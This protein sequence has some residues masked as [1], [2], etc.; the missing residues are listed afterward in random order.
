MYTGDEKLINNNVDLPYTMRSF[1]Q[2]GYSNLLQNMQRGAFAE[3]IVHCAL[4]QGN[5]DTEEERN[6]TTQ[7]Y[8]LNG[9]VI[10]STGK[11]SR[12]EV[13]CAALVQ[14][15][16]IKHPDRSTFTIRPAVMPDEDGDY[17]ENA[18]RQR[19]NDIYIFVVYTA[20]EKT[21]NILDLSW[22]KF[23][24]VPTFRIELD[25]K[26]RTQRTI[27]LKAVQRL[28]EP[29]GFTEL[30]ATIRSVCDE[31]PAEYDKYYEWPVK[32]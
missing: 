22:W 17:N 24:V 19:N 3:Y 11:K 12:L 15:W 28:T 31:I 25:P 8:D 27:S 29:V 16:D 20:T 5:V 30:C 21:D 10:P 2:W 4:Q 26:L 14:L 9:P 32:K 1:W 23:Y 18:P 13:K 7:S 6:T